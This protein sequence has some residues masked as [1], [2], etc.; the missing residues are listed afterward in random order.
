MF[1]TQLL[2]GREWS[3]LREYLLDGHVLVRDER[4]PRWRLDVGVGD[5]AELE[6]VE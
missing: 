2:D 5:T 1:A 3:R 4:A 6:V